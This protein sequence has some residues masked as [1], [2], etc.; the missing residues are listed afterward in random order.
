[1]RRRALGWLEGELAA[2]SKAL[3][4]GDPKVRA[5]VVATLRHWRDDRDLV[6]VRDANALAALSE[7][8]RADWGALWAEVDRLLK[9][10][11]K[12]P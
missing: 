11:G 12:A 10:A 4:Y 6:G 2:W 8:E 5:A 9:G 1:L 7:A 3:D